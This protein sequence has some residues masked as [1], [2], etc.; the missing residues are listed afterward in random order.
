MNPWRADINRTTHAQHTQAARTNGRTASRCWRSTVASSSSSAPNSSFRLSATPVRGDTAASAATQVQATSSHFRSSHRRAF[1][2]RMW[3]IYR[4]ASCGPQSKDQ[5]DT[6]V[7]FNSHRT[8]LQWLFA[9]HPR[10]CR[11]G[12]DPGVTHRATIKRHH[13]SLSG[14]SIRIPPAAAALASGWLS[15][16]ACKSPCCCA[17]RPAA[18][19]ETPAGAETSRVASSSPSQP[20]VALAFGALPTRRPPP[21]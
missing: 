1:T 16:G 4:K 8:S 9:G 12:V 5:P 15:L 6:P 17:A 21:G 11:D 13:C 7:S 14:M 2:A 10:T 18:P 3:S 19:V 20:S